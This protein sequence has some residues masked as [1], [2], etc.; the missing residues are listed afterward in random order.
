MFM[1]VFYYFMMFV[2]FVVYF[3][4]IVDYAHSRETFTS[5]TDDSNLIEKPYSFN[6]DYDDKSIDNFIQTLQGKEYSLVKNQKLADGLASIINKDYR[7]LD[8]KNIKIEEKDGKFMM[9]VFIAKT[10]EN[11]VRRVILVVSMSGNNVKIEDVILPKNTEKSNILDLP[12]F[13]QSTLVKP[14]S[15]DYKD[16]SDGLLKDDLIITEEIKVDPV[17]KT[18]DESMCYGIPEFQKI[19]DKDQCILFGGVW[20]KPVEKN[21]ECPFY[22]KNL[23]Y[24]NEKGGAKFGR[25]ELPLGMKLLGFRYYSLDELYSPYCYNCDKNS[26]IDRCCDKQKNPDYAFSGDTEERIA[27]GI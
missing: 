5:S 21:E 23:N 10:M 1:Q 25:C 19:P 4:L 12:S 17:K 13:N 3:L 15:M 7:I 11:I 27:H 2:F 20:D 26:K 24:P 22:K 18:S 14:S 9:P 8:V 6:W 16:I